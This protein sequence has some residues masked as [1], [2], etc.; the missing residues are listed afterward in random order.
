M[1]DFPGELQ[2]ILQSTPHIL[3]L[4]VMKVDDAVPVR[5]SKNGREPHFHLLI[6]SH[7]FKKS[8][9]IF[10]KRPLCQVLRIQKSIR[11]VLYPTG[12]LCRRGQAHMGCLA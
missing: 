5:Q 11:P 12:G 9:D 2:M 10:I 8:T 1:F 3:F 6:Y 7:F 4:I